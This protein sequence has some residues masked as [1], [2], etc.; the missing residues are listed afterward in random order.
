MYNSASL[1]LSIRGGDSVTPPTRV[2]HLVTYHHKIA[3]L[4]ALTLCAGAAV[5]QP[6]FPA[7]T[8]R[9][10]VGSPPGGGNDIVA[11][12][13]AAK[14]S[15]S[16]NHQ[17]I[18]DNRGGAN[19]II[20]ME[21][22]ARAAPDGHTW[23]MGTAGHLSVNA[24]YYP[25][26]PFNME[27]DFVPL[28]QVVSLPFL[29]YLHPSVPAKSL[30][31]LVAHAKANPGKLA[32]SSSGDGGLPQFAGE[33]LKLTAGINT[34]RIPYKGSTPAFNDLLA[35]HVQYCIEAVPIGLQHVR[36]GRLLA[37][38]TTGDK[39][40]PF[41]PDVPAIKETFAGYEVQN[42]YG[43][44][45]PAG[46]PGALVNRLHAEIVKVMNMPEIRAKLDAQGTYP[47]GST[48]AAFAVFRKA[49]EVKWARVIKEAHIKAE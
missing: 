28:M 24:V 47:V 36:S 44:V 25:K 43:M 41:L 46:T 19:G 9:L 45:L 6:A 39:R 10:I 12:I 5:A 3:Y 49:E 32:W 30:S 40:L 15:E 11:R 2:R 7:K 48:P 26:L 35:G 8:V 18:V 22:A 13:L 23:Y 20:G 34:R 1:S 29:L 16:F 17:V 31:E 4:F 37:L 27:R 42:W 33:M 21:L 14:L 38:A